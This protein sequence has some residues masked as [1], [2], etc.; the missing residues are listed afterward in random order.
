MVLR[1]CDE[2]DEAKPLNDYFQ[3]VLN[4][5][6]KKK[7]LVRLKN[8]QGEHLLRD[9]CKEWKNYTILVHFMRKMFVY[10]VKNYFYSNSPNPA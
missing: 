10:L 5:Q 3:D 8:V 9:F 7:I 1:L 6:I 4:S 2:N